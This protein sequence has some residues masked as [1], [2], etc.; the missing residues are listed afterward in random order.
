M[1]NG[2]RILLDMDGVIVNFV[3]GICK[4]I[5]KP[6]PFE[7]GTVFSGWGIWEP[8][9]VSETEFWQACMSRDFWEN[10]EWTPDGERLLFMAES[11]VGRNNV[12]L[13]TSPTL[14]PDCY[15]GKAAWVLFN[16][17]SGYQFRCMFG[18][19]KWLMANPRHI[20]VDDGDHNVQAYRDHGGHAILVPRPWN[21][22]HGMDTVVTVQEALW[23]ATQ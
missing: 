13:S 22:A 9:G 5:G 11:C 19:C 1:T 2:F 17:P 15:A 10:L 23:R 21:S 12:F 14:C 18:T 6:N 4:A 7:T 20:L 8:I 16:M 3:D